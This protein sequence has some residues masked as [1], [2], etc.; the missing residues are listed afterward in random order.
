MFQAPYP[1]LDDLL[2]MMGGAD[3]H[4]SDIEAREGAVRNICVCLRW[5]VDPLGVI[6]TFFIK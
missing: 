5:P 1:E 3:K 6:L 2:E 4:M